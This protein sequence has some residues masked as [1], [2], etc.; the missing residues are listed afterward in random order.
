MEGRGKFRTNSMSNSEARAN[1]ARGFRANHFTVAVNALKSLDG[2][3]QLNVLLKDNGFALNASGGEIK[4]SP[5]VFLEQSST[6]APEV[7]VQFSDGSHAIASCYYEFAQRYPLPDG[8]LFQGFV[9]KSADKIF[10][11]TDR[12]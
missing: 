9:A 11:S 10:E 5:K 4:G 8:N 3:E 6:M 2:I 7:P 12:K 1:T